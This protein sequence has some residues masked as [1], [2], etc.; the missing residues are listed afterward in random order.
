MECPLNRVFLILCLVLVA[1]SFVLS[2]SARAGDSRQQDYCSVDVAACYNQCSQYNY[3]VMN[4][5]FA[6]PRTL[7]CYGECS[8]AYAGCLMMRFRLGV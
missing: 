8:L 6:S 1:A 3:T 5:S 7:V 4:I 2:G